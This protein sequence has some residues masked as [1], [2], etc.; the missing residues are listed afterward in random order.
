MSVSVTFMF[1]ATLVSRVIL[2]TACDYYYSI[3][4]NITVT[5]IVYCGKLHPD[6]ITLG[7][8]LQCG[9]I[10]R[11]TDSFA[12]IIVDNYELKHSSLPL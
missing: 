3:F 6:G 8:Q 10:K 12:F 2:K 9:V 1:M 5:D 7:I 11:M 4:I